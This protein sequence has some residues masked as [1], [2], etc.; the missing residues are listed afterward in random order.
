[1]TTEKWYLKG[2]YFENCNCEV[3]C[4]CVLPVAPGAPTE[5]HCDVALAFHIDEGDFDGIS[6]ADLNFV[7]A[8]YTPGIM[9]AGNWTTAFYVDERASAEQRRAIERIMSGDIGGPMARWISLITDFRGTRY[10]S[11]TYQSQR[12][13]RRVA[14]P[15]VIDFTVEGITAGRGRRVMRLNNTGH[16]VSR[17]LA[18]AK[19]TANTYTDHGMSWDNTGK[20]GHYAAFRWSWP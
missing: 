20:N 19:G 7:V 10:C 16:P 13:T 6:L 3:L 2:D 12:N 5:G 11:I 8:T 1:M 17:S 18:L 14:I 4:P 15:G 9:G